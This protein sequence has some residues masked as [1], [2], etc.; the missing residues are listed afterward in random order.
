[1]VA[2]QTVALCKT[3]IES[4]L[5]GCEKATTWCCLRKRLLTANDRHTFWS[6]II[7]TS[8]MALQ[9]KILRKQ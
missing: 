8:I 3:L 6:R 7:L 4:P 9:G 5:F 2:W 1:M